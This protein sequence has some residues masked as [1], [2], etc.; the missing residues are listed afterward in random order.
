MVFDPGYLKMTMGIYLVKS[1]KQNPH[2]K[3]LPSWRPLLLQR[4]PEEVQVPLCLCAWLEVVLTSGSWPGCY[5]E[6]MGVYMSPVALQ[7][8]CTWNPLPTL[9]LQMALVA[10]L[11]VQPK[12][13]S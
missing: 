7:E 8:S 9:H 13:R 2:C 11:E 1:Q 5:R 3:A 6:A 10:S 12:L 4:S